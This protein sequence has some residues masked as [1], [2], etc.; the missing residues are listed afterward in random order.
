MGRWRAPLVF[1][2]G[3]VLA[4]LLAWLGGGLESGFGAYEDEP[5]HLVS[6]LMVRDYVANEL[7]S[8]PVAYSTTPR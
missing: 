8:N 2:S 4:F 6:G 1:L 3:A 5:S 7:G